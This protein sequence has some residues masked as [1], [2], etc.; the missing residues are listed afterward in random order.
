MAGEVV[1]QVV[2]VRRGAPAQ[3][4]FTTV[5]SCV[6]ASEGMDRFANGMFTRAIWYMVPFPFR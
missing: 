5:C 3:L 1:V 2:D 4:L 6:N